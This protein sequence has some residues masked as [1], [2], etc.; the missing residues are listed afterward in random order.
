MKYKIIHIVPRNINSGPVNVA[1]DIC[2]GL[3]QGGFESEVFSLRNQNGNN[4]I[5]SF[6]SL[7]KIKKA[8]KNTIFHSHGIIPDIVCYILSLLLDF[9]WISTVH[10]DPEEDLKFI[11]P[12]SYK[13]ICFFWLLILKRANKVVFLTEYISNKQKL[14]NKTFIHNSRYIVHD[15]STRKINKKVIG[16]CG[17]LIERKNIRLLVESFEQMSKYNLLVAG[18]GPLYKSLTKKVNKTNNIKLLG[19]LDDL[20]S[21]WNDI[22]IL[23]LPSFAEGLPLVAIEALSKNIPLILINLDN[24]RGV[25]SCKETYFISNVDKVQLEDAIN[26]IF[27]NYNLYSSSANKTFE[28]KFKF[29]DWIIKYIGVYDA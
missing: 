7:Y 6:Y 3:I 13:L 22:D 23:I 12:R 2:I 25:F 15:M 26:K 21:F 17:A 11:Y 14:H 5:T 19:H 9:K 29:E 28:E 27:L 8:Y 20:T 10:I 16:F 24:Y 1:K 18:D 4:I